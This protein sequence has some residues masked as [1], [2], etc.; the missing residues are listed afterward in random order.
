M[1]I[2]DNTH[3]QSVDLIVKELNQSLDFYNN[4]LGF[5]IVDKSNGKAYLSANSKFP[6]LISIE[7]NVNAEAEK[8]NS[9][10]LYH[11]A[12]RFKDRKSL[13]KTFLHLHEIGMKFLG[14][15]DHIVS[16]AIYLMDPDGNGIELYVDK[17]KNE[18]V[19]NNGQIEMDTLPLDLRVLTDEL[20]NRG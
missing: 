9:A 13:A 4:K 2:P 8:R 11:I 16:E 18:W 17:P 5:K 12:F 10:G 1:K 7:E 20:E 6:Y 14:F 15:S 19:W 3:I